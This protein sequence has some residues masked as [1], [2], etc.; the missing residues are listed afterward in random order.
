MKKVNT[1]YRAVELLGRAITSIRTEGWMHGTLGYPGE[2][3]CANGLLTAASGGYP[4]NITGCV[5]RDE[6]P[7]KLAAVTL[8]EASPFSP[9]EVIQR[10][11]DF[12]NQDEGQRAALVEPSTTMA[13]RS[14]AVALIAINDHRKPI[15]RL[16]PEGEIADF[17]ILGWGDN[18]LNR[19]DAEAWFE[20]AFDA[21]AAQL[22]EPL[23]LGELARVGEAERESYLWSYSPGNVPIS[24]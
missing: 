16:T 13:T 22:P 20:R 3:K 19:A 5:W 4:E 15:Y 1:L 17:T 23:F 7:L 14:L 2:P 24:A 12:L 9:D 18:A 21:L 11:N 8:I 10:V 6:A